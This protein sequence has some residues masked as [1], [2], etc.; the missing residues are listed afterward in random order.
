MFR[1][2]LRWA[3]LTLA[4]KAMGRR[5]PRLRGGRWVGSSRGRG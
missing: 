1:L 4:Y 2:L 5:L 3:A